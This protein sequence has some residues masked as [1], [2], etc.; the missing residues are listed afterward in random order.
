M[1]TNWLRRLGLLV[2]GGLMGIG[3][4]VTAQEQ[5]VRLPAS[6]TYFTQS[7]EPWLVRGQAEEVSPV[8]YESFADTT[9]GATCA[10]GDSAC[11]GDCDSC[12]DRCGFP[13]GGCCAD[14][15]RRGFFG[16]GELL[17]LKG[18]NTIGAANNFNYHTG[19]RGWGGWQREDGLGVR[20]TAFDYFQRAGNGTVNAG[21]D[22]IDLNYLDGEVIDSF[23]ICNWN[24]MV[25]G[26]VRY[27]DYREG[28]GAGLATGRFTGV[29]PVVSAQITRAINCNLSLTGIVKQSIL[30]GSSPQN[31]GQNT[32]LA[33]TEIQLGAQYNREL[34]IGGIGFIRSAWEA[35]WY[36]DVTV[37]S[38]STSLMGGVLSAGI[39]R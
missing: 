10:C 31:F 2:V 23:N 24:L 14:C 36:D 26:G 38:I 5:T 6:D 19:F 15:C 8:A 13:E 18:F 27:M 39:M 33:T 25:G 17:F 37:G 29:G 16:G 3:S 21:R 7:D 35:Q 4:L 11:N 1:R 28:L 12:G 22:V 30:A 34:G 9:T 32:T 20:L